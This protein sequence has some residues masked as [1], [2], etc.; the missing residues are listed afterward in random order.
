MN[1]L[2]SKIISGHH[3]IGEFKKFHAIIGPNGAGKSNLMDAISFVLGI[4][5]TQL[6]GVSLRDLVHRDKNSKQSGTAGELPKC[7]VKLSLKKLTKEGE[8]EE[9]IEFMRQI[10]KQ[11]QASEYSVSGQVVTKEVYESKLLELGININA[12]N[13]LVFQV[14]TKKVFVFSIALIFDNLFFEN[15]NKN[16]ILGRFEFCCS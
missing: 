5:T 2:I 9:T 11:G 12:R 15:K 14:G 8:E 3:V 6:R 7:Y 13:F 16:K 4:N 10:V 1:R